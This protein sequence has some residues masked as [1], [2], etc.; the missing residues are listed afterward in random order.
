MFETKDICSNKGVATRFVRLR[1]LFIAFAFLFAQTLSFAHSHEHAGESPINQICEICILAVNDGDFDIV[2]D[3][4]PDVEDT[5][6]F[7]VRIDRLA[8]PKAEPA[9]SVEYVLRSIDPPSDPN[10]RPDSARAPPQYI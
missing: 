9:P 8:I 4:E 3:L 7:W 10:Q 6:F 1:T 2:A 5:S